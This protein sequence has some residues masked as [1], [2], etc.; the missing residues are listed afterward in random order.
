VV[1][2]GCT[3]LARDAATGA[4]HQLSSTLTLF[5]SSSAEVGC[6]RRA[7][8]HSHSHSHSH[9]AAAGPVAPQ[10]GSSCCSSHCS[11]TA[12]VPAQTLTAALLTSMGLVGVAAMLRGRIPVLVACAASLLAASLLSATLAS[13]AMTP[14]AVTLLHA[15]AF[16][17]LA[18]PAA[19]DVVYD[20]AGL[21]LNIHVLMSLSGAPPPHPPHPLA[22]ALLHV[23]GCRFPP[24]PPLVPLLAFPDTR[25]FDG[26]W[27]DGETSSQ[28]WHW[29]PRALWRTPR[30]CCFCSPAHTLRRLSC[31]FLCFNI[32]WR[33]FQIGRCPPMEPLT[34]AIESVGV[35]GT[36]Q[37]VIGVSR[38]EIDN[39]GLQKEP[40]DPWG[41]S[42]GC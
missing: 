11:A 28:R 33:W 40:W 32:A 3:H 20:V 4:S 1:E 14:V 34:R 10:L 23:H 25:G 42:R 6:P 16:V 27:G 26:S 13:H 30:C 8:A 2:Q 39:V 17:P 12:P 36:E 5:Y 9:D 31:T 24:A 38:R 35:G 15:A 29:R 21:Q 7:K 18:I 19:V 41:S 37:P 22:R